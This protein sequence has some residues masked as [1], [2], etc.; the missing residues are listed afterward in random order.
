MTRD[1]HD[2]PP[3]SAPRIPHAEED[4]LNQVFDR[5]SRP[6]D[7]LAV[8]RMHARATSIPTSAGRRRR[9]G[10]W[11]W[12]VPAAAAAT[13]VWALLRPAPELVS[14]PLTSRAPEAAEV[15]APSSSGDAGGDEVAEL[16][17]EYYDDDAALNLLYAPGPDTDTEA[18][19]SATG[20]L[21]AELDRKRSRHP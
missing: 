4:A 11:A 12:L 21:L 17:A 6:P 7:D 9:W 18:W 20:E 13:L 1:T 10:R 2:H 16:L 5:T 14:P 19:L 15:A 3:E 8:A